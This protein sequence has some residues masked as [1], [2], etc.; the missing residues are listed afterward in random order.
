MENCYG[1]AAEV[2]I[3][4]FQTS[5]QQNRRQLKVSITQAELN[6]STFYLTTSDQFRLKHAVRIMYF[7][8]LRRS[9]FRVL[10]NIY[11][12]FMLEG[13]DETMAGRCRYS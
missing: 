13:H 5:C 6:D 2:L 10:S 12:R 1:A 9:I 7:S 3:I 11:Y 8:V 4:F